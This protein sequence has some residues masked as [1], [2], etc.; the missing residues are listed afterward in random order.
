[1]AFKH[2]KTNV[3]QKSI[4]RFKDLSGEP[5]RMLLP[6][7]GHENVALVSLEEAV[8]P[9]ISLIPQIKRMVQIVKVRC[10]KPKD[11]LS[12]D[13][14]ASIMLYT[15]EWYPKQKSFYF[16]LNNALR[17]ENRQRLKPWFRYL[18]LILTALSKLPSARRCVCRGIRA[19][20]HELYPKGRNFVWWGFSSC[21]TTLEVLQSEDFLGKKGSRTMFTIECHTGKDVRNHSAYQTE[22][23][24]LLP[25]ARQFQVVSCLDLGNDL[26]TIQL[27]EIEPVFP[28]MEPLPQVPSVHSTTKL[29]PP[30]VETMKSSTKTQSTY[31]NSKL[32]DKIAEYE[33][34]TFINL[35]N[36][37]LTDQDMTIIVTQAIIDKQCT[38]LCLEQNEI[39][40]NGIAIIANGLRDNKTLEKLELSKNPISDE[41]IHH[42]TRILSI[43]NSTLTKLVCRSNGITDEGAGHIADLLENNQ[44]LTRLDLSYNEIGDSG[45]R[46]LATSLACFNN[47]LVQLDLSRNKSIGEASVDSI[48]DMVEYNQTC[49]IIDVSHCNLTSV[50][51]R[52]L[53]NLAQSRGNLRLSL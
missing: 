20:L 29:F 51:K 49:D 12:V 10:E 26:H 30:S 53:R 41:G 11:S 15:M 21:T 47:T 33:L 25:A 34:S 46:R 23:E 42:L 19:D 43:N 50:G 16:I 6:I 31:R 2:R 17:A 24:I 32:E 38:G 35:P 5:L 8:F 18:K 39:T 28:L 44:I 40:A 45:V 37:H 7:Q 22:D 52:K 4:H 3:Q 48:A 36:E 14:S 13:G 9:L 1:M 27:K